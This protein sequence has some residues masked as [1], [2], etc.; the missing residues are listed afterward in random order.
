[1][2]VD[3]CDNGPGLA[4]RTAEQLTAPF[5]STKPEGMGMGLA[6]CRSIVEAHHG[7]LDVGVAQLGGARFSF[8]LPVMPPE[9]DS[10]HG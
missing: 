10:S 3:V 9:E 7:A 8:S 1:V 5:Y 6:I 4:G 2:V